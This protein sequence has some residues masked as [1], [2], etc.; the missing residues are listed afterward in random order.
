M[1]LEGHVE[2]VP[3]LLARAHAAWTPGVR[4]TI[5]A[6]AAGVPVAS[7]WRELVGVDLAM[8]RLG[9]L[10]LADRLHLLL[11]DRKLG[12]ALRKRA[13]KDFSLDAFRARLGAL[14]DAILAP[15]R[16]AA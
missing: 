6:M 10:A 14:Y 8:P 7:P 4:A 16:A 12:P 3:A 13:E 15:A 5:E 2:D 9:S 11:K 1:Q